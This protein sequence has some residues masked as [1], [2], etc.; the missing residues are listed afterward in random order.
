M[1]GFF[2]VAR[3]VPVLSVRLDAE[4]GGHRHAY[5]SHFSNRASRTG[6]PHSTKPCDEPGHDGPVPYLVSSSPASHTAATEAVPTAASFTA[7]AP[8]ASAEA[9]SDDD[10]DVA[11]AAMTFTTSCH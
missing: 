8:S 6:R 5:G 11:A 9:T 1:R 7:S 10:A 4:S 3:L 2:N